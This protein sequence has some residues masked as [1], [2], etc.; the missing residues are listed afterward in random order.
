MSLRS[1][2]VAELADFRRLVES[3]TPR[4]LRRYLDYGKKVQSGGGLQELPRWIGKILLDD[5]EVYSIADKALAFEIAACESISEALPQLREASPVAMALVGPIDKMRLFR[6][7]LDGEVALDARATFASELARRYRKT[8]KWIAQR[9]QEERQQT[10]SVFTQ[11]PLL[12]Q[13]VELLREA[14][15]D[16]QN[17]LGGREL[18]RLRK[19]LRAQEAAVEELTE[20]MRAA[21]DRAHRSQAKAIEFE[22]Q[23]R[24]LRKQLRAESD[25]DD[26]LRSERSRRIQ[27]ERQTREADKEI[28]RLRAECLKLD[29]RLREVAGSSGRGIDLTGFRNMPDGEILGLDNAHLSQI[30][31]GQIRRRFAATF[32][33]D[34][35][36]QLPSWVSA[37]FDELLAVINETC[38]R[39]RKNS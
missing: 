14:F 36:A 37:L 3:Q 21:A 8:W 20:E 19:D 15:P 30:E 5:G 9:A 2:T 28:E 29:R 18:K 32:H 13:F 22:S 26:R 10:K 23:L 38:D 17:G 39:L 12:A 35:A 1:M 31:I 25:S 4:Q 11:D 34:R 27:L 7:I 33:S 24:E 16:E 6:Q